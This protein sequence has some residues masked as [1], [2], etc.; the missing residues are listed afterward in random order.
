VRPVDVG[1]SQPHDLDGSQTQIDH[2]Q[3]H[4]IVATRVG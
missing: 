4:G 1:K 2:A 3:R